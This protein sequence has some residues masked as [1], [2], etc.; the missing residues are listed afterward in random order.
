MLGLLYIG[1]M[2]KSHIGLG[3]QARLE[4]GLGLRGTAVDLRLRPGNAMSMEGCMASC[5]TTLALARENT[6][7]MANTTYRG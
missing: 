7:I 5:V 6:P 1:S 4:L 3:V 2:A